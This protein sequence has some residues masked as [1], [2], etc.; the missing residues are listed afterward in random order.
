MLVTNG[1]FPDSLQIASSLPIVGDCEC[2]PKFGGLRYWNRSKFSTLYKILL[3]R[4]ISSH[5]NFETNVRNLITLGGN[6]YRRSIGYQ[7]RL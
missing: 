6:V 5:Q 2:L 3:R 7:W 1:N 4:L